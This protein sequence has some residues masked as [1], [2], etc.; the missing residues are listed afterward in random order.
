MWLPRGLHKMLPTGCNLPN[1]DLCKWLSTDF[2]SGVL[3][4]NDALRWSL[5]KPQIMTLF[6][7]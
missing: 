5:T 1:P 4:V 7:L 3:L 6:Y 2:L